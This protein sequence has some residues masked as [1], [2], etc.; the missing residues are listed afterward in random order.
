MVGLTACGGLPPQT[1]VVRSVDIPAQLCWSGAAGSPRCPYTHADLGLEASPATDVTMLVLP[2][3]QNLAAIN[4][5]VTAGPDG[6]YAENPRFDNCW[7]NAAPTPAM[8]PTIDLAG[9][10]KTTLANV[11]LVQ[12]PICFAADLVDVYQP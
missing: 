9:G 4:I 7:P 5:V 10:A 12:T 1:A 11:L 3:D 2:G 8:W 6:L